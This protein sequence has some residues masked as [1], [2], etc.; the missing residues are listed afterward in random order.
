VRGGGCGFGILASLEL[1]LNVK[2]STSENTLARQAVGV[3]A[4]E[5]VEAA[6]EVEGAGT[7]G[8]WAR[9]AVSLSLSLPLPPA[10]TRKNAYCG[11]SLTGAV[12]DEVGGVELAIFDDPTIP[13]C[14]ALG[15]GKLGWN[16]VFGL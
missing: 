10:N 14:G 8:S 4:G 3:T 1:G 9:P 13:C 16:V 11:R 12:T 2:C 5:V 6:V 15:L 7:E